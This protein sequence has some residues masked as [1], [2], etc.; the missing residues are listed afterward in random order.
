MKILHTS[1]WHLGRNFGSVSLLN[2]QKAFLDWLVDRCVEHRVDLVVVSG[3]VFDR[4]VA[5]TEAVV[6][7]RNALER[8]LGT[9]ARVVVI[10][11]NHDGADRVAAYDT[12]LDLSGAFVR[13]GY[14]NH[15][16]VLHL[17]FPDGPLDVAMLPFL[18]P[19]AAPDDYSDSTEA[20]DDA[21]GDD[22]FGRRVRRTHQSVLQSAIAL[23]RQNLTAPRSVAISHAYV[24]GSTTSESERHLVVGGS[25]TVE[26][27]L[28]D[29]FSY[30][31]LGHLH[32]P[33]TV[34][35]HDT[36]RYAGSP[37]AYS[38]S[39]NHP[40]SI[41]IVDMMPDGTCTIEEVRVPVGRAVCTVTG[42]ID[43]LLSAT[44]ERSVVESFVRAIVTDP[45]VVLDAKQRLSVVY[46]HVVEI[47]LRPPVQ[48]GAKSDRA[49]EL[50]KVS[51]AEAV[52]S[53]WLASTGSPPS[54]DERALLHQA[55]A[56]AESRVTP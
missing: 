17:N 12:L 22:A 25:G 11:G 33:Q 52:E 47:E 4:A 40:K 38:F 46:P 30:A 19:Q 29:G 8:L 23:A 53:F 16:E 43:D 34:A 14:S 1:D 56:N 31:A 20:L 3:D 24:A 5:P 26:A 48:A 42:T 36:V 51:A 32:R 49:F 10:T 15:G 37:L 39:E 9:G 55:V 21:P 50:G 13:G 2:D 41:A 54:S 27:S 45:G 35:G 44:P 18:D 28:F 7:F 6:L